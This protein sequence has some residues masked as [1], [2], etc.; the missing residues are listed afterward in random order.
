MSNSQHKDHVT[1]T[2]DVSYIK[3][4]DVTH[5][6]SDV[7]VGSIAKF[8]IG[9][10]VLTIFTHVALWALF[11]V[12]ERREVAIEKEAPRSKM[13]LSDK[14]RLPP[15]PRLQGAPGFAEK[16]DK[17]SK[18]AAAEHATSS[19]PDPGKPKDPLWEIKRLQEQ[20][21][22]VLELGPVDQSGRR[23]GMPIEKAKEEILKQGLPVRKQ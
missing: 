2:P 14:E 23:F 5:E 18:P 1:E 3:N 13:A 9:L 7:Q 4:V 19:T 11:L 10:L 17:E 22:E 16:L 20:W 15:E 12:F 8:V 21:H 6:A